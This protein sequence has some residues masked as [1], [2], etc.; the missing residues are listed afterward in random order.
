MS[1]SPFAFDGVVYKLP[2]PPPFACVLHS[3]R[4]CATST[5]CLRLAFNGAMPGT[6]SASRSRLAFDEEVRSHRSVVCVSRSM[7]VNYASHHLHILRSVCC[8]RHHLSFASHV[9]RGC[10]SCPC[11]IQCVLDRHPQPLVGSRVTRVRL[12][13]VL[14]FKYPCPSTVTGLIRNVKTNK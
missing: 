6:T 10:T 13:P 2:P 3:I 11:L 7:G 8:V 12:D 9:Q 4:L 1:S 14:V 5:C